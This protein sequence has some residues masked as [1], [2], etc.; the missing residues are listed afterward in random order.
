MHHEMEYVKEEQPWP[1]VDFEVVPHPLA[2]GAAELGL[3]D[4]RHQPR[5]QAEALDPGLALRDQP[6]AREPPPGALVDDPDLEVRLEEQGVG[7]VEV[8]LR[9]VELVEHAEVALEQFLPA[10][11]ERDDVGP[12]IGP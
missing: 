11:L 1:A 12:E 2:V 8:G 5:E 4:L 6:A 9:L 7:A 10:D 3:A